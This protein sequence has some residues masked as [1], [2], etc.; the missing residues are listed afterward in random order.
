VCGVG[1]KVE[2]DAEEKVWPTLSRT[3]PL[4]CCFSSYN[5]GC[6]S[7]GVDI[8]CVRPPKLSGTEDG[9]VGV[10]VVVKDGV[11]VAGVCS[12][13]TPSDGYM[14][15]DGRDNGVV[16]TKEDPLLKD[17]LFHVLHR[18]HE[19]RWCLGCEN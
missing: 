13:P 8:E 17:M 10:L 7:E 9:R 12:A 11:G 15:S 3:P 16:D 2:A 19:W 5:A 1:E 14:L 6:E 18:R 4:R